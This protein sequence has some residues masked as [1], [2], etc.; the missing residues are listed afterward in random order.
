ML[1]GDYLLKHMDPKARAKQIF[2][3]REIKD[4]FKKQ[5]KNVRMVE[6]PE[7]C[8]VEQP[9]TR[10]HVNTEFFESLYKSAFEKIK[11]LFALCGARESQSEQGRGAKGTHWTEK[12]RE[13][14]VKCLMVYGKNWEIIAPKFPNKTV[15]QLRNFFQNNKD[16][17]L[18]NN[19]IKH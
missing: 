5:R 4:V 10:V 9:A 12:E 14:F 7:P 11:A 16:K 19:Y 1:I 2:T 15:K 8:T 6:S 18:L 3:I 13:L 17:M